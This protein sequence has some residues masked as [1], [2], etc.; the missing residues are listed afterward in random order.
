MEN[1]VDIKLKLVNVI[2]SIKTSL[3]Q[4]RLTFDKNYYIIFYH[5]HYTDKK[6]IKRKT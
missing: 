6:F 5:K 4:T 3:I 2:N 1:I